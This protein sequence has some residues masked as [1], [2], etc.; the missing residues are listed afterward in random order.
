MLNRTR[1]PGIQYPSQ[2]ISLGRDAEQFID[3]EKLQGMQIMRIHGCKACSK[4]MP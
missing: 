2:E 1:I 4:A 3:L